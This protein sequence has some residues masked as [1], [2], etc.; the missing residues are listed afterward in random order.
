MI[1]S[2]LKAL[3][4]CFTYRTQE[5][6]LEKMCLNTHLYIRSKSH[7]E[8]NFIKISFIINKNILFASPTP[9]DYFK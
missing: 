9:T 8:L 1:L 4:F 6:R 3:L 5:S 2:F 7:R